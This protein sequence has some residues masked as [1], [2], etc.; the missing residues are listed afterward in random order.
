V[1]PTYSLIV[2]GAMLLSGALVLWLERRR[3]DRPCA[4]CDQP[5]GH[6]CRGMWVCANH[7]RIIQQIHRN[8]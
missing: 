8:R 5:G 2:L 6:R 1:H 7:R 3:R 4:I